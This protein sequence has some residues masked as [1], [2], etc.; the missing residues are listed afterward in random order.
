MT[1]SA[2]PSRRYRDLFLKMIYNL[3]IF[4][5]TAIGY[6]EPIVKSILNFPLDSMSSGL[7]S[8]NDLLEEVNSSSLN[9]IFFSSTNS[10]YLGHIFTK[11][12]KFRLFLKLYR[13]AQRL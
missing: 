13:V 9:I 5:S 12:Q 1:L 2:Y 6:G 4:F 3:F 10:L 8:R 11:I 7:T